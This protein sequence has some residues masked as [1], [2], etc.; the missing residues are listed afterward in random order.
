MEKWHNN[1]Y[2]G[3]TNAYSTLG[4]LLW[5]RVA[6]NPSQV[7]QRSNLSAT[8]IFLIPKYHCEESSQIV[9]SHPLHNELQTKFK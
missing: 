7:I 5:L 9:V 8:N 3:S 6:L 2:H 4:D 1:C